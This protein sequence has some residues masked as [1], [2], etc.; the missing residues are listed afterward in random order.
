MEIAIHVYQM[1]IRDDQSF[2]TE[3]IFF[4]K[5]GKNCADV[6]FLQLT[7]RLFFFFLG[8]GGGGE[9]LDFS[10]VTVAHF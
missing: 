6:D 2:K 10:L 4:V 7:G 1:S 3:R 8:G 9:S 5:L